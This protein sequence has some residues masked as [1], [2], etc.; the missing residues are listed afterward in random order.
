[1]RRYNVNNTTNCGKDSNSVF[2][3]KIII[4][5]VYMAAKALQREYRL[6]YYCNTRCFHISAMR[7]RERIEY[8]HE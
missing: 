3:L 1:M 5:K 2:L 7:I 8:L 4:L 6:C